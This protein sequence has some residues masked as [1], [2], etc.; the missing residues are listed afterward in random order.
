MLSTSYTKD[1]ILNGGAFG[2]E[3][4]LFVTVILIIGFVVVN[5][6]YKNKKFDFLSMDPITVIDPIEDQPV[7]VDNM[8]QTFG[9]DAQ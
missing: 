4:G 6:Y 7:P 9:N 5:R 3:G 8:D 2:P 1:N